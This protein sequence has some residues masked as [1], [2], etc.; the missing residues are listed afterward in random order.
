MNELSTSFMVIYFNQR[1]QFSEFI[2]NSEFLAI[3]KKNS[4]F[5]KKK[6]IWF[7]F[8]DNICRKLYKMAKKKMKIRVGW[9][10]K[11]CI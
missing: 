7:F 4:E 9:P 2:R 8:F 10:R 3:G 1:C 6:K 11:L 5:L